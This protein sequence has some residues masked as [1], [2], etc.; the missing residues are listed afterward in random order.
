MFENMKISGASSFEPNFLLNANIIN[1]REMIHKEQLQLAGKNITVSISRE[2]MQKYRASIQKGGEPLDIA[3]LQ[4]KKAYLSKAVIDPAHGMT[5]DFHQRL[6]KLNSEKSKEEQSA[7]SMMTNCATVYASMHDEIKSGYEQGTREYW[8]VDE[9]SDNG[10][11]K[12]TEEEEL[13]ALDE[14]YDFYSYVT[15]GYINHGMRSGEAIERALWGTWQQKERV[16]M[17]AEERKVEKEE[18]M[19][20]I[21]ISTIY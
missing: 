2:G 14:A 9:Q 12:V 13:A 18:S 1:D 3:A 16:D 4:E 7:E 10:F 11:R 19:H 15:D 21:E 6:Y 8:V 17:L 5:E 20:N